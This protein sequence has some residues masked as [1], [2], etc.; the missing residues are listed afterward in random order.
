MWAFGCC[1]YEALTGARA[2]DGEDISL[3]LAAVLSR[4][5]DWQRLPAEVPAELATLLRRCLEKDARQRLQ[6][7][8]DARWSFAEARRGA[9]Q[10]GHADST[11]PRARG[12]A[13]AAV[14]AVLALAST[15]A[16]AWLAI[17][18]PDARRS[19]ESEVGGTRRS[20]PSRPRSGR[21]GHAGRGPSERHFLRVL[22]ERRPRTATTSP[23]ESF[24]R[25][26][27]SLPSALNRP[28]LSSDGEWLGFMEALEVMKAPATGGL[29]PAS[30]LSGR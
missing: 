26:R 7:L 14:L 22:G 20:F 29:Q 4:E 21:S 27:S 10:R 13:L 5:P 25:F 18:R 11:A 17:T 16:A 1:L 30:L 2:F 6:D 24:G 8:G 19:F 12:R 23:M 28:F 15:T 3:I 9:E